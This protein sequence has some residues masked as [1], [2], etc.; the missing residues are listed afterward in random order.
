MK[1]I[2][3]LILTF[4]VPLISFSQNN[5]SSN[6]QTK[7]QSAATEF[8]KGPYL[9]YPG[10][11]TKMLIMWQTIATNTCTVDYGTDLNY[12]IGSK[13]TVEY[14][15][16]HQHK[17]TLDA[18]TP[19]TKYFYKVTTNNSTV[20][21]GS[22][23]SGATDTATAV[24][25]YAYGDTRTYPSVHNTI[26]QRILTEIA[27][28]TKSQSFIVTSGDLVSDGNTEAIWTSEFFDPQY[29]S[30][31]GMMSQLPYLASMGNHEGQG[32]LFAKYFPYPMFTSGRYYYSFDYG[33][34]HVTVLDQYTTLTS[35]SVQYTW[36]VNDLAA[37]S[38]PWKIILCHEPAYTAWGASGVHSNNTTMQTA[39][40][41]L[42]E[43]YGVQ[44]II[45]GHNHFYSRFNINNVMHITS[46][47]GGAPLY[48]P[49]T[50][51]NMVKMDGSNHFCKID[52]NNNTLTFTAKKSTGAIIETF[53]YVKSGYTGLV[54]VIQNKLN[55][56]FAIYSNDHNI[57]LSNKL[58]LIGNYVLYDNWGKELVKKNIEGNSTNITIKTHGVYYIRINA[59]DSFIVKKVIVANI[60]SSIPNEGDLAGLF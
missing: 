34:V 30:I 40:Q 42:C 16:A 1:K 24:S 2:S 50:Q 31:Q 5:T 43:K 56:S 18:L 51:A 55:D 19:S 26:A 3:I 15:S 20:K 37:S 11:N 54:N 48:I 59:E 21:T 25:F 29:T 45:A 53:N 32:T 13:P 44:F 8:A 33:S 38:K 22:F 47:G 6:P 4:L 41:P 28:D 57:V 60:S 36:L 49:S 14:G 52:I 9:L 17:I 35:G 12:S 46:G 23:M 39:V 27:A 58:N 10:N 7:I